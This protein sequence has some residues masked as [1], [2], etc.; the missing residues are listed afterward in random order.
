MSA[1]WNIKKNPI[2]QGATFQRTITIAATD[3]TGWLISWC[4]K[5]D[6]SGAEIELDNGSNGGVTVTDAANGIFVILLTDEQTDQIT[7]TTGRHEIFATLLDGSKRKLLTGTVKVEP[8]V[9]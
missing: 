4:L 3:I 5:D 9:C 7:W 6:L 1:I 8:R 2:E